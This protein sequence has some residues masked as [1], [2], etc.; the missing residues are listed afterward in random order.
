MS[1]EKQ[2]E[3]FEVHLYRGLRLA[4]VELAAEAGLGVDA[5]INRVLLDHLKASGKIKP[6]PV[7]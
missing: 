5:Y 2:T 1:E 3:I 6:R 4:F 7:M